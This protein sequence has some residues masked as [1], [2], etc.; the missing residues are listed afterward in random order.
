MQTSRKKFH[1]GDRV[2]VK[3]KISGEVTS[4]NTYPL[5]PYEVKC[6]DGKF[7]L[8]TAVGMEEMEKLSKG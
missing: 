1:I 6:E 7:I 4:E 5:F 2:R 3:N 8:T